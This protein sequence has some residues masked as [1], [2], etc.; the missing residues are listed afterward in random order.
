MALSYFQG[1]CPSGH[2]TGHRRVMTMRA[3]TTM[4]VETAEMSDYDCMSTRSRRWALFVVLF[5]FL[6]DITQ[7]VSF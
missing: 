7:S 6:G 1:K 5:S 2:A 4:S 3:V